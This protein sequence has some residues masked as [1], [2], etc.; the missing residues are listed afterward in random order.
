MAEQKTEIKLLF[1][2]R[3]WRSSLPRSWYKWSA[4]MLFWALRWDIWLPRAGKEP[5]GA[6]LSL[7]N[8][9]SGSSRA[10]CWILPPLLPSSLPFCP[11]RTSWRATSP[12][13]W[14][15]EA[16]H[17]YNQEQ[18][19]QWGT[20]KLWG[21][22]LLPSADRAPCSAFHRTLVSHVQALHPPDPLT[23]PLSACLQV[24]LL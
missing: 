5:R 19:A 20:P 6:R 16:G 4:M 23:T 12:S 7:L 21:L 14:Q 2:S 8:P 10:S 22:L 24:S 9:S 3:F 1:Q 18:E 11:L 15:G 17:P 13:S